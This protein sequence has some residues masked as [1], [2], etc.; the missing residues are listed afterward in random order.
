M[1]S[2]AQVVLKLPERSALKAVAD[3]C[4]PAPVVKESN[5]PRAKLQNWL[6]GWKLTLIAELAS[7]GSPREGFL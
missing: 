5:S 3:V 1:C 7:L 6:A 2:P 4:Q